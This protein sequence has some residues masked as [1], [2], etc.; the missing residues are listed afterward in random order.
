MK[1]IILSGGAGTRLNPL[2][3]SYSKQLL[4]VYDKPMIYYPLSTLMN[5]NIR[6]ILVIT[7]TSD[8]SSFK[9]LLKDGSQWGLSISYAVQKNPNG[10][11]ESFIIGEKFI[12]SDAVTLILGDNIFYGINSE[13]LNVINSKKKFGAIIFSYHVDD[14]QRYGVVQFKGKK[15]ISISEKPKFPKSNFVATGM[16]IYDNDVI[17]YAKKLKPSKR[18]EIE[19]TDIN[20]IYLKKNKLITTILDQGSVWLDAGTT[21]SLLQASQFVQTIQERQQ[22]QIACPEEISY[23]KGWISNKEFKN[24]VSCSPNNDYGNYLRKILKK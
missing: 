9:R 24:I 19:I 18:G 23:N 15:V 16:Y 20:K 7:S 13:K 10:I 3:I 17:K 6:D 21:Q 1:G 2:T 4:P 14:P 8:L 5:S 11:A 22:I 12:S